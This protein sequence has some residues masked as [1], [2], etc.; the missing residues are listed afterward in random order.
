MAKKKT[1]AVTEMVDLANGIL[2]NSKGESKE[3][4]I[5]TMLLLEEI[6]H[7]TGNYNGFRYLL[8]DECEG[9]PGVNYARND[10]G[11]MMPDPDIDKRFANTD[12]TRVMYF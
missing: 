5:G 9:L 2:K 7:R 4:R 11:M 10:K 8:A 3:R 1:F 12:S 6:L